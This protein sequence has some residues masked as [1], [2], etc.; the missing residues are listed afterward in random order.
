[1][2]RLYI[3]LILSVFSCSAFA[4]TL[5][6]DVLVVGGTASGVSAAIQASRSGVKTILLAEGKELSPAMSAAD[7]RYLEK[8]KNHFAR[9]AKAATSSKDSASVLKK[10]TIPAGISSVKSITDTVKNLS[11]MLNGSIRSLEKNGSGWELRLQDGKKLKTDLLVDATAEQTL[12]AMLKISPEAAAGTLPEG[13]NSRLYR[14]SVGI[15][16]RHSVSDTLLSVI[17]LASLMPRGVDNFFLIPRY[18]RPTNALSMPAGQAAGAASA[19]CA[20]FKTSTRNLNIRVIQGEL[21][22]FEAC[23]VP[24]TDISPDDRHAMALQHLGLTGILKARENAGPTG[25]QL[26]DTTGTVSAEDLRLPMKEFYYRSQIWF[27]GKKAGPLNIED[28]INLI[29]FTATR[30]EEVRREIEKGWKTRFKFST[31]YDPKRAI[32]RREFA[33]LTDTYLQPFNVRVDMGG[34]LMN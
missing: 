20:F 17:P 10:D 4:Q 28:A 32:N 16:K 22:A 23:L 11:V 19:F 33:V 25:K 5:R 30:G 2:K 29:M 27:A 3:A 26:F 21:L 15:D 31:T 8:I 34:N 24:Y 6:T 18:D 13:E 7:L 1:M 12:A 14:T 9:K